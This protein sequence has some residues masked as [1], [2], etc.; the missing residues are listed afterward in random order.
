[1]TNSEIEAR[2]ADFVPSQDILDAV[3]VGVAVVDMQ[4]EDRP[5]VYVN[6]RFSEITGY[7]A[8]ESLGRNCRFLQGESTAADSV[9]A[10]REAI[11]SG[12]SVEVTLRNYRRDGRSFWNHLNLSP[13]LDERGRCTYYV[14]VLEDVTQQRAAEQRLVHQQSHDALTGLPNRVALERRI[15]D[16]YRYSGQR[17]TGVAVLL[18]DIDDFKT[19]RNILG[20]DVSDELLVSVSR[21]LEKL[22]GPGDW[23]ARLESDQFAVLMPRVEPESE[24][25]QRAEVLLQAVYEPYFVAGKDIHM[26]ARVGISTTKKPAEDYHSV[27]LQAERASER[28]KEQG[29]NCWQWH[30]D[31]AFQASERELDIRR[32]IRSGIDNDEFIL[33]YQPLVDAESSRIHTVEALIRWVRPDHGIIAP[34]D[35]IPV[36]ERTG[37]IIDIGRWVLR[38]ACKD[39]SVI[40]QNNGDHWRVAVNISPLQFRRDGF[41]QELVDALDDADLRPEY[42]ELEVTESVLMSGASRSID[43][44]NRIRDLGV[45]VS[46]DDFGTGYSSLSYLRDLPI[47][48]V[49]LDQSFIMDI[50]DN[51]KTASI[52]EGVIGI[53]HNLDLHV[54]AE[55]VETESQF[56]KLQQ[57]RCDSLQGFYFAKPLARREL[58]KLPRKLPLNVRI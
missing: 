44:L 57:Q 51:A 37:Q 41:F 30:A 53:A 17:T 18:V 27:L 49:K 48:K 50:A 1:M 8:E 52:V 40:N 6:R 35:F 14:G 56:A 11:D 43:L 33:H 21:R 19:V 20:Y 28:A 24:I 22:N 38:Q 12:R 34:L 4:A 15:L 54:V 58:M 23:V 29:G 31:E 10:L 26:T 42:L 45:S 55:G 47:N 36:A 3:T 7:S 2:I 16:D 13:L 25:I 32:H 46:I 5:L 9:K 39:I